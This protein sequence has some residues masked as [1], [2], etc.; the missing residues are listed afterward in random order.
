MDRYRTWPDK[1]GDKPRL[2]ILHES[3][4]AMI[5]SHNSKRDA[6]I[7]KRTADVSADADRFATAETAEEIVD[8][9]DSTT[10]DEEGEHA[11]D[12]D[13]HDDQ[14]NFEY[15]NPLFQLFES[16]MNI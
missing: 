12:E 14:T 4:Q 11:S 2:S 15:K 3:R 13:Q 8:T 9:T 10:D 5:V 6:T 1:P 7:L 16:D